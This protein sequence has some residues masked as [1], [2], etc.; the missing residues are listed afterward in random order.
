MYIYI[1]HLYAIACHSYTSRK[2]SIHT[3]GLK[4]I[5]RYVCFKNSDVDLLVQTWFVDLTRCSLHG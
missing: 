1:Y 4:R 2:I 3:A 5:K